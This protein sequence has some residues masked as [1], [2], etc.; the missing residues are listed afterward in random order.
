MSDKWHIA[1]VSFG[2]D[3]LAMLLLILDSEGQYPLDEVVFFD[4]GMEFQAIYNNRDK[5]IPI[6][7][8]KG[9]KF[10]GLHY[11]TSF[12]YNFCER[13]VRKKNGTIQKGY[14]WCG[15]RTRWGTDR[16]QLTIKKY[17][18]TINREIV[19]YIGIAADEFER[20]PRAR[21][22]GQ[23][24]PLVD[25]NMT[26]K[27]ALD[28]CCKKGYNWFEGNI[29]LYDI[30]DRVSCWCCKNNNLKELRNMYHYLPEYW[31]KLKEMQDK[32]CM[33]YKN[34]TKCGNKYGTVEELE[35]RFKCEDNNIEW[36]FNEW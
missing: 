7:Q 33:P 36:T 17:Y 32:T 30:M 9:I 35:Y 28:F 25:A 26:E 5:L 10:T 1:S 23:I 24:L 14:S 20:I 8:E 16:K 2:K 12:M 6:L 29:D 21:A 18:K 11:P 31:N 19:E 4:W 3:S 34:Y 15:G 13:E 22:K 27:D